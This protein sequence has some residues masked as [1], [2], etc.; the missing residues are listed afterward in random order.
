[1]KRV[2]IAAGLGALAGFAL[3]TFDDARIAVAQSQGDGLQSLTL[4]GDIF[5]RVRAQYVE[6]VDE[7]EL[8]E[9]AINGMLAS[10][11]PH[12]S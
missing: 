9:T 2:M 6:E 8:V 10:L 11:D 1:M 5:E 7:K 4:F 12:S 3:A